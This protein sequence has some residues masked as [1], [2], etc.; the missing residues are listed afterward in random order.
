VLSTYERWDREII[1]P[2]PTTTPPPPPPPPHVMFFP[3]ALILK[4]ESGVFPPLL[5]GKYVIASES[6]A[7][8]DTNFVVL[9]RPILSP[10]FLHEPIPF[11]ALPSSPSRG[12]LPHCSLAYPRLLPLIIHMVADLFLPSSL[13]PQQTKQRVP[14]ATLSRIINLDLFRWGGDFP[15]VFQS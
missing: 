5:T 12:L 15:P 10:F 8:E 2:P 11:W 7:T 14:L 6:Y 4:A 3:A 9:F 1:P 13:P